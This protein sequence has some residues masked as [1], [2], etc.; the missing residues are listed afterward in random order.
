MDQ[1]SNFLE[2]RKK[3]IAGDDCKRKNEK[4][5]FEFSL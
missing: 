5:W 1:H 4:C 2:E 3:N